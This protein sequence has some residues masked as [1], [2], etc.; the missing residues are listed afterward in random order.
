MLIIFSINL[1]KFKKIWLN[2]NLELHRR[3]Y[4]NSQL[5]TRYA[6]LLSAYLR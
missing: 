1:V 6:C 2:P 5:E 4:I 3:Q